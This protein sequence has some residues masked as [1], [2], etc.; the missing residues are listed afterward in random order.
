MSVAFTGS[1]D[2]T[3]N[4][5]IN[6]DARHIHLKVPSYDDSDPEPAHHSWFMGIQSSADQSSEAE[7]EDWDKGFSEILEVYRNSPLSKC[8]E[9]FTRTVD[10]WAKMMGMNSDHRSKEKKTACGA[11]GKKADAIYQLA[12]EDELLDKPSDETDVAFQNAKTEMLE[13]AGGLSTWSKLPL[14]ERNMQTAKMIK[15]AL[16]SLGESKYALLSE[17]DQ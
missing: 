17:E 1:A 8:S 7:L 12:G 13:N 6:Y 15:S 3:S 11:K 10:L 16:I 2:G 5:H 4:K 14:E 9:D